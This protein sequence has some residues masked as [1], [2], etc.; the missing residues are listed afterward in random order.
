MNKVA[1]NAAWIIA[2]KIIQS[3]L[4]FV[5]GMLTARYLGPSNYGLINYAVSLTAFVVP[6]MNLGF[7]NVLVKEFIDHPEKEGETLGTAVLTSLISSFCCIAGVTGF[8]AIANPGDKTTTVVCFLYSLNLIFQALELSICWFQA[9]LL[10]KFTSVV[11]LIAYVLT[12]AY[13][14]YLLVSQSDIYWF[15][16]TNVID[17]AIIGITTLII[18]KRL[19]GDKLSFSFNALKRIFGESRHYIVSSM[20]IAVFAQTD[21]IMIKHMMDETALG[22]YGAAVSCASMTAFVFSAIIDSFR[23]SVLECDPG[24][25]DFEKRLATLFS[26]I[27]YFSLAQ[28]VLM[29]IFADVIVGIIYGAAYGPAASALRI[30]VWYTTFS[31]LGAVRGVWMLATRNQKHLWKINL[32]GAL[33]NVAMNAAL[34]PAMGIHGAALASLITQ[35][36]TNVITGFILK[37]V[38]PCNTVMLKSLNPKYLLYAAKKL[39]PGRK[40]G[41]GIDSGAQE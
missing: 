18:Y 40:T 9:K 1:K 17:Y 28:S 21:R 15:A 6:L 38:R 23:P 7:G 19:G 16:L 27:I 12:A 30:V 2:C 25:E 11:G 41:P 32:S 5:I 29:T 10:S 4:S 3:V 31:Y 14:I 33:A 20:M 22:Y 39:L 34:I 36:F 24:S 26:V 8:S 37:P 35:F 13:R